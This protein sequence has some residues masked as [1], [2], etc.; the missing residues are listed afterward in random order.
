MST[1]DTA[2]TA[3]ADG[4]VAEGDQLSP[5]DLSIFCS[6]D[7][8]HYQQY[9]KLRNAGMYRGIGTDLRRWIGPYPHS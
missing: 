1:Q 9:G 2:G 4:V 3:G 6:A 7:D 8:S 5:A